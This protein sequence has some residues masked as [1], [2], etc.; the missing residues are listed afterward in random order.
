M[1]ALPHPTYQQELKA[2]IREGFANMTPAA[3]VRVVTKKQKTA[4]LE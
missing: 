4:Y 3:L 1:W 2:K